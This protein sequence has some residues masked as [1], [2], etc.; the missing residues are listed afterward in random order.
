MGWII[1]SWNPDRGKIL[2]LLSKIFTPSLGSTQPSTQW[3][4]GGSFLAVRQTGCEVDHSPPSS[5]EVK[6]VWHYN[7][8]PPYAFMVCIETTLP[9]L[10]IQFSKSWWIK[11]LPHNCFKSSTVCN[12][13][14]NMP[15]TWNE[16]VM[17]L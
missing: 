8:T 12:K 13:Y 3:V 5:V 16:P 4:T 14:R 11:Q 15:S 7:F 2:K 6:D 9:F 17:H 1:Q 10:S